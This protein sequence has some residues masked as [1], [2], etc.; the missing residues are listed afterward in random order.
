MRQYAI[1][2]QVRCVSY[3]PLSHHN[4]QLD[5]PEEYRVFKPTPVYLS[6]HMP[7]ELPHVLS[8][9]GFK[10]LSS[11]TSPSAQF[12]ITRN[13][14]REEGHALYLC[15]PSL[16]QFREARH[17]CTPCFL[18]R[19][20]ARKLALPCTPLPAVGHVLRAPL[21]Q[22]LAAAGHRRSIGHIACARVRICVCVCVTQSP[23]EYSISPLRVL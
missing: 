7:T 4:V 10:A 2:Q 14:M 6:T 8:R 11:V 22:R 20:E 19:T 17:T 16:L 15:A 5:K 12:S 23:L 1:L 18:V 9:V 3:K 21:I 13:A